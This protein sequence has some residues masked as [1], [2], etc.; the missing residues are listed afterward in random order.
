MS[1]MPYLTLVSKQSTYVHDNYHQSSF[2]FIK[3]YFS[4]IQHPFNWKKLLLSIQLLFYERNI[5][6]QWNFSL[7]K[8]I[9]SWIQ[10]LIT[11]TIIFINPASVESKTK[12]HQSSFYL[13]E[14]LF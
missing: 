11:E 5:F 1:S 6:H 14:K 7:S 13:R 2:H 3:K 8:E 9:F 10:L 4:S 12:F